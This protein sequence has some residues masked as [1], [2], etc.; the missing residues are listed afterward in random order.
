MTLNINRV[1][2]EAIE[3]GLLPGVS[4][5]AGDKD[6]MLHLI[7]YR[8]CDYKVFSYVLCDMTFNTS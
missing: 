3:S 5:L 8:I 6:G 1:Y 7:S 2:E 4:L